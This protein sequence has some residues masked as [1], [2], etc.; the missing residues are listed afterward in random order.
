MHVKFGPKIPNR[1]GEMSEN[2]RVGF[3]DSHCRMVD[4]DGIVYSR[5]MVVTMETVVAMEQH[6]LGRRD[7]VDRGRGRR[8]RRQQQTRRC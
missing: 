8:R 4:S 7:I 1:L 2:V 6:L 5:K 3:F